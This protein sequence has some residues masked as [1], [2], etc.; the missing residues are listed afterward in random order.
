[1]RLLSLVISNLLIVISV[2]SQGIYPNQFASAPDSNMIFMS[3]GNQG[4]SLD[5]M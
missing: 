1:M 2:F 3:K 5:F 4:N